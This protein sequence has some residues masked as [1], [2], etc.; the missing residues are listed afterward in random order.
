LKAG[1][2]VK[3]DE[4]VGM[5]EIGNEPKAPDDNSDSEENDEH[6][7]PVK[8][9]KRVKGFSYCLIEYSPIL[10]SLQTI[11]AFAINVYFP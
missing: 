7:E 9:N 5:D 3:D 2:D 11:K 6:C 8:D 10:F 4:E 1:H